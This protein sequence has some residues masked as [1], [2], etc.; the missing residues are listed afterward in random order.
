MS[1][2]QSFSLYRHIII[3]AVHPQ[4]HTAHSKSSDEPKGR[5]RLQRLCLVHPTQKSQHRVHPRIGVAHKQRPSQIWEASNGVNWVWWRSGSP[6][7]GR[8]HLNKNTTHSI[9][10]WACCSNAEMN[11]PGSDHSLHFAKRQMFCTCSVA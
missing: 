4:G 7:T 8:S 1:V 9:K 6:E 11:F 3:R 10:G 5:R 2:Q